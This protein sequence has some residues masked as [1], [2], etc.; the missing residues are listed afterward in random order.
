MSLFED[1]NPR[2]LHELLRQIDTREAAL[3]DFQRDF[4][5]D[6]NATQELIVSIA[7]GYPAGSLLRIRN[8]RNLFACREIQGAPTLDRHHT[9]YL[10]LDGQQRLTSLYQA[11]YGVGEHRYYL[12]LRQLSQ[13]ATFEDCLFHLRAN[14]KQAVE[15]EEFATQAR[16]LILPLSVLRN[17]SGGYASWGRKVARGAATSAERDTLEEAL[18]TIEARWIKN[19]DGYQFPVVTL[20]EET[21]AEAV[22]TIFETLNRTGVKLSVFEL[23]TARFWPLGINLRDLWAKTLAAYPIIADFE[24]DPY[25]LLQIVS[26]AS[27]DTPSCARSDVLNLTTAIM[28]AWWDRAAQGLAQGLAFLRDDCGVITQ[29][30]LPYDTIVNPLA[31]VLARIT[32]AGSPQAG[33]NRH[34]LAR[35]FWCSVYGQT[36][37]KASN[38]QASRDVAALLVWL[39]GGEEPE[40]V[41]RFRF[42]PQ[43]LHDVTRR[44]RTLYRGT[45]C[46]LLSGQ[47]RDFYNAA[48]LTGDV[49]IDH[50]VDD[51]HIFPRAYLDRLGVDAR[52]RDC[53]LNRTLIDRKTNIL[54]GSR[55]PSAYM[56]DIQREFGLGQFATLLES[57]LLPADHDSPLWRD[58]FAAF[59][60]WRQ[61]RVWREIRRVTGA[62]EAADLQV[63]DEVRADRV[64]PSA[65]LAGV[66]SRVT[67]LEKPRVVEGVRQGYQFV[68]EGKAYPARNAQDVL[69]QILQRLAERDPAFIERLAARDRPGSKVRFL[70]QTRDDLNRE[71]TDLA[72]ENS[73]E[74]SAGWWVYLKY[75]KD[76]IEKKIQ[77]AAA[78]AGVRY[79]VDLQIDL[80]RS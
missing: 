14:R 6:P 61:E 29:A 17:D 9:T 59:L 1:T 39:G 62:S 46:L 34:R 27:R 63:E 43:I 53:I 23:L 68:L 30:W 58:D 47:P 38:T 36:Y 70:A 33:A 79:G 65:V 37:E 69:I 25:Y 42:D 21:S 4:V 56:R 8:T 19:I 76:D 18:D 7:A 40:T 50:H 77:S 71:R 13:G 5:W 10:V 67:P 32:G 22:C 31:A 54:I 48:K 26:L 28:D 11:F 75:S 66:P 57:H 3:P 44:Q 45:I 2:G 73:A 20:S 41:R 78:V 60:A 35:W 55:P 15:L 16:E 72:Q 64:R 12:H 74:F 52:L 24:I 80:G 51:H 49:M